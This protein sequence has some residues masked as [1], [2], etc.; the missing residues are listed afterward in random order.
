MLILGMV[1]SYMYK[2]ERKTS[3]CGWVMFYMITVLLKQC[4]SL[5][6]SSKRARKKQNR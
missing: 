6:K 3:V 5:T 1:M 4:L 2:Q